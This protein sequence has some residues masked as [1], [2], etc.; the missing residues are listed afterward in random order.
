M[1]TILLEGMAVGVMVG[2]GENYLAAFAL[3][4]GYGDV[5]TGLVTSLPLLAGALV[6]LVSPRMIERMGSNR[7]W[8]V[9]CAGLQVGSLLPLVGG[10]LRGTLPLAV[11]ALCIAFYWAVGLSTG[12]PWTVWIE[13]LVPAGV[14][15][16]FFARRTLASQAMVLVGL[17]AAGSLL[18]LGRHLSTFAAIFGLA[19]AAR[20]LS[21]TLLY[22]TPERPLAAPQLRAR[23]LRELLPGGPARAGWAVLSYMLAVQL[24][25]NISGPY[26][27]PYMLR[28]LQLAYWQYAVIGGAIF[29]A[30]IA[31]LHLVGRYGRRLQART[32]LWVGG[33]AIIP[34]AGAWV[35]SDSFPYL[36]AIQIAAGIAWAL[37][38]L[39]TL[40]LFFE[41]IPS[42]HRTGLLTL[43][44]V[45]NS[46]ALV[47]GSSVG[48]LL[49]RLLG[50]G[51]RAYHL[52]FLI[53]SAG[54]ALALLA[55]RRVPAMPRVRVKPVTTRTLSVRTVPGGI[56][57]PVLPGMAQEEEQL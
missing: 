55:L 4:L 8:V 15:L 39:S 56:H 17:L 28:R 43:F 7:R 23:P 5:A 27:N 13:P 51:R 32:M 41:A 44:N 21:V 30:R 29:V 35:V 6:Q 25:V 20:L 33:V 3:S 12:P 1:R 31:T 18:Q 40:L 37:Y 52:L 10:A 53:S 14:R 24:V 16:R 19:A 49:L 42:S 38:E 45:A 11:F 47:S 46:A 54:R 26:F 22:H 9:L 48:G 36:I 34:M 57:R 2:A 50:T